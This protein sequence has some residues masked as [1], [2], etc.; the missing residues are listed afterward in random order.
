MFGK[1]VESRASLKVSSMKE[2][3][4]SYSQQNLSLLFRP[5]EKSLSISISTLAVLEAIY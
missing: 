3:T 5:A 4:Y 2:C 1:K